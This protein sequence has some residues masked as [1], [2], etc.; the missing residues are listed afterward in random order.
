MGARTARQRLGDAAEAQVDN[1][2]KRRGWRLIVANYQVRGGE[3]DRVYQTRDSVV[4]VEVRYRSRR[5]YGG[6]A[7]SVTAHKQR[8]VILATR[9]LLAERPKLARQPVRFDVVGVDA[10]QHI[11][12]IENAFY[13]E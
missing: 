11:D 13:A 2:A 10:D 12:W 5:D 9:H 7:A 3:L 8:R 6:A 4:V 1:L